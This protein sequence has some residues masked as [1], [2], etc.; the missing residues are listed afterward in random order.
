MGSLLEEPLHRE[1]FARNQLRASNATRSGG[2]GMKLLTVLLTEAARHPLRSG[3]EAGGIENASLHGPYGDSSG[4]D[5]T[6]SRLCWD[7]AP[8]QSAC[9]PDESQLDCKDC[10]E[11]LPASDCRAA[12]DLVAGIAR[13]GLT[14]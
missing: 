1:R 2:G 13:R 3:M 9:R 7:V 5:A 4:R 10:K 11:Q 6:M 14:I 12:P 8:S